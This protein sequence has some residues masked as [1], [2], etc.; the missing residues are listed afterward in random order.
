VA[1]V[2][3]TLLP[4]ANGVVDQHNATMLGATRSLLKAK[5]MLNWLWG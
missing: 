5:K 2:D 4:T 1:E 3:G